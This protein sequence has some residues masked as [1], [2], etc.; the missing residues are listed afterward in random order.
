MYIDVQNSARSHLGFEFLSQSSNF[1]A[2]RAAGICC[3]ISVDTRNAEVA[4]QAVLAG[5][6]LVNDVSGR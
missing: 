2:M 1:R 5:A 3:P 4:K 6:D